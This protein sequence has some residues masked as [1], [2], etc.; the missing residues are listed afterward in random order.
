[1]SDERVFVVPPMTPRE[2]RLLGW[3][4]IVAGVALAGFLIADGFDDYPLAIT[5]IAFSISATGSG[6]W[7]LRKGAVVA[8]G[9]TVTTSTAGLKVGTAP[10]IPWP[11][12]DGLR[13]G[14]KTI[15]VY[16]GGKRVARIPMLLQDAPLAVG[17]VLKSIDFALPAERD[18]VAPHPW[19]STLW[20]IV[21]PPIVRIEVTDG[22]L[23]ARRLFGTKVI[24]RAHLRSVDV[25]VSPMD[26]FPIA[27]LADDKHVRLSVPGV[28]PF[29]VYATLRRALLSRL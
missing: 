20:R 6:V 1:M 17:I 10:L 18:V 9:D 7:T 5:M 28:D 15:D 26:I 24:P 3:F 11:A 22:A 27:F 23:I 8:P 4:W 12:I 25:I 21:W 14:T 13:R 29:V 2:S 16:G 19:W